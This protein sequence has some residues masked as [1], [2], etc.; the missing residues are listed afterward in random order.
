MPHLVDNVFRLAVD[1]LFPPTMYP[2]KEHEYSI[3]DKLYESN[4]FQLIFDSIAEKD[5]YWETYCLENTIL[6]KETKSFN[7]WLFIFFNQ[8]PRCYN[9]LEPLGTLTLIHSLDCLEAIHWCLVYLYR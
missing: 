9:I 4:K 6:K 2:D 1:P 8:F 3:P 7:I 5:Q